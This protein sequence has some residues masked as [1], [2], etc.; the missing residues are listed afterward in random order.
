[1][2]R[3]LWQ[4]PWDTE[5][6]NVQELRA[7]YLALRAL[8]P[9]IQAKHVLGRTDRSVAVYYVNHQGGTRSMRCLKMTKRLHFWA[10]PRLASPGS[11]PSLQVGASPRRV[12]APRCGD[13][14]VARQTSLHRGKQP[15]VRGGF[16]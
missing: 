3:G 10:F 16:P 4:P 1:M 7:I 2:V 12:A 11:R 8:L 13:F 14:G 9:F 6:I 15:T 5:H